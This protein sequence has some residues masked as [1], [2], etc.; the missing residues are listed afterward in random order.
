MTGDHQWTSPDL[1]SLIDDAVDN[2]RSDSQRWDD[3]EVGK[4]INE[5][6]DKLAE[7]LL[8]SAESLVGGDR[9]ELLRRIPTDLPTNNTKFPFYAQIF[10][11]LQLRIAGKYLGSTHEMA[12][13]AFELLTMV[14][15]GSPKEQVRRFLARVARCYILGLAPEC[16]VFSRAAVENALDEK[17]HLT[18]TPWPRNDK[19]ESPVSLRIAK[20][21]DSGWLSES[22]AKDAKEIWTRGSKSAHAD[23][24][25]VRQA[26]ET[27][28]AAT[29]VLNE[30][31]R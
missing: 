10:E 7:Y 18:S 23:P 21:K 17:Y 3:P 27:V 1:D 16:A 19:G 15:V 5:T 26:R 28:S 29:R 4:F 12:E 30:L 24:E 20:A 22:V 11:A 9:A 13:R 8:T 14:I 2:F 6:A 31:Y 25:I